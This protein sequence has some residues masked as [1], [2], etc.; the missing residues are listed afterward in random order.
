MHASLLCFSV[1]SVK[2]SYFSCRVLKSHVLRNIFLFAFVKWC[3]WCYVYLKRPFLRGLKAQSLHLPQICMT[4]MVPIDFST[5]FVED[6]DD[7]RFFIQIRILTCFGYWSPEISDI[8]FLINNKIQAVKK[9]LLANV[10]IFA[11]LNVPYFVYIEFI[12]A[13]VYP[14]TKY[15]P[16]SA[17]T[18]TT[19][20][21]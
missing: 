4:R 8:Y 21:I 7:I 15:A 17:L 2:V 18:T 14:P 10:H 3:L 6:T 19:L 1:C 16:P 12:E 20:W 9:K 5:A 13:P 11:S